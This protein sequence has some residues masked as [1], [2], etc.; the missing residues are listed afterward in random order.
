MSPKVLLNSCHLSAK[1]NM[2][3]CYQSRTA[4]GDSPSLQFPSVHTPLRPLLRE[5]CLETK[6][7]F[8]PLSK[9]R[10]SPSIFFL[11]KEKGSW[12]PDPHIIYKFGVSPVSGSTQS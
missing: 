5:G 6:P 10:L 1:I 4:A 7:Y 8:D 2:L 12:T 3:C 11:N 9:N